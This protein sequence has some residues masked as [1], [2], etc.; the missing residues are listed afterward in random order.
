L[1]QLCLQPKFKIGDR[2]WESG[3]PAG[4]H[5]PIIID[6]IIVDEEKQCFVYKF[7]YDRE[8]IDSLNLEH[9]Y[10]SDPKEFR[11]EQYGCVIF[12]CKEDIEQYL[13]EVYG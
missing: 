13:E 2:L 12:N 6:D 4:D 7:S 9:W 11:Y 8:Y 5:F 3:Y 10:Q 1:N